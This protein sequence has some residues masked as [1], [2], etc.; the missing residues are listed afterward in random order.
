MCHLS[1]LVQVQELVISSCL[2]EPFDNKKTHTW[3]GPAFGPKMSSATDAP[4]WPARREVR[5]ASLLL[6]DAYARN[7]RPRNRDTP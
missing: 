3:H 5:V 1:V 6:P 2:S 4:T 7:P